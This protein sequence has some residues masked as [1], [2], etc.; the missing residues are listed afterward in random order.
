MGCDIHM[1]VEYRSKKA[2]NKAWHDFGKRINPGRNYHLFGL[3]CRGVRSNNPNGFEPKGKL[4]DYGTYSKN[5]AYLFI[6]D[7][8]QKDGCT[9]LANAERW[10]QYGC[11]IIKN[12]KGIPYKVEHPDWHSHSW[13]T[14]E[15]F[16]QALQFYREEE[17]YY[18]VVEYE[19][20]LAAMEALERFDTEAR[21]VFWF[22][23]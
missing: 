4:T 2:V 14:T 1:Y 18:P 9:T 7:D 19:A 8:E 12:E 16:G 11:Q 21:I 22:D 3:L 15:E 13:L 17:T 23:N 20:L 10:E 6:S 5:D